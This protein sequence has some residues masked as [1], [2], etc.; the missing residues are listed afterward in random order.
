MN[1]IIRRFFP[2]D[3]L[4][5]ELQAGLPKHGRVDIEI[6]ADSSPNRDRADVKIAELA[7]TGPA[8]H[9]NLDTILRHSAALRG[10][11]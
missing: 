7:G 3:K 11:R 5:S 10:D 9:G 8:V 2:V 6:D 1:K 4:P